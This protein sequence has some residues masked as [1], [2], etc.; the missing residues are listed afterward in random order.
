GA[1]LLYAYCESS[2]PRIQ[3]ITR[4]AYGG[5]YVVMNSKSIGADLAFAWPSAELAVMGPHGAVEIIH[6]RELEQAADPDARRAELV[7]E[8]TARHA[9]PYIA[10][11]RGYVDDVIEPA[12]TRPYLVRSL[13]LLRSKREELPPRKHGNVPL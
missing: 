3:V 10:A 13:A 6:R 11:E 12:L 4:K 8:Y 2:V 5:A 1:K 7:A 9:N